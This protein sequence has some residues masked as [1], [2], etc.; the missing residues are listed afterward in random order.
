VPVVVV[1]QPE[2][3]PRRPVAPTLVAV[4][5][6][7][8]VDD[9]PAPPTRAAPQARHQTQLK[10]AWSRI[11]ESYGKNPPA[12][13]RR[14]GELVAKSPSELPDHLDVLWRDTLRE[15]IARGTM[16]PRPV[17]L[18]FHALKSLAA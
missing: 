8:A 7:E 15:H 17:I 11:E 5:S 6:V 13:V 4:E 9:E 18:A 12:A 1:T 2:P 14:L 16:P 3:P 10:R